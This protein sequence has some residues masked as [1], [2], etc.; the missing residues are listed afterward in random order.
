M[1]DST[2]TWNGIS[3]SSLG[4]KVERFPA[5][6]R[7]ARKY[8]RYSVPGRNGDLFIWQDAWTNYDQLYEIYATEGNA[9]AKWRDI[10]AWL[11]PPTPQLTTDNLKTLEYGGYR[12]LV[13]SYEPDTIRLAAFVYET[14]IE[15]SWNRLGRAVIRFTCRPERF[16]ND[17][18]TALGYTYPTTTTVTN[19]TD[20]I[21][22]PWIELNNT[23]LTAFTS[24][25]LA[26]INGRRIVFSGTGSISFACFDCERMTVTQNSMGNLSNQ[27]SL[28]DGWPVLTPGVNSIILDDVESVDIYPRW[29]RI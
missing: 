11:M 9:P 28:P 10:M 3:S 27:F 25:T 16:T 22:K 6:N 8:D 20:R 2:I 21:A 1:L 4:V 7:P 15:N 17:A 14:N 23:S 24:G 18:F 29:W 12:Q 5:L 26:T 19:P 13:D